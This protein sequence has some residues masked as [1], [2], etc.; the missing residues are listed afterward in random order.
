[1]KLLILKIS[2][3][4]FALFL[5]VTAFSQTAGTLTFIY[6]PTSHTCYTG[7]KNVLA[8]WVQTSTG[9]FVKTRIRNA[10]SGTNDHLPTWAVN[11]GGSAGNCMAAACNVTGAA[12]T[13]ATLSS[14]TTKNITWDGTDVTGTVVADGTYKI[15]IQSTWNHGG[16]GTAT[17]SFTFTKGPS[18][19]VQAP[20]ND[21]NF[22]NMTL[23]WN[24]ASAAGVEEN[25]LASATIYPN[26]STD[27]L[28]NVEYV[29]AT[30]IKVVNLVGMTIMEE[31][32]DTQSGTK[33]IDLSSY[34]NGIYLVSVSNGAKTAE[35]KIVLDK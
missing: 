6:T 33:S 24:P 21:A 26:P 27:G 22:T 30:A 11:S 13:G 17:R 7:S 31:N 29:N 3:T 28:F 14:F 23:H 32:L 18:S 1:M 34:T 2:S 9:T 10:G 25:E 16:T 20:A 35:Y 19:D 4:A 15:T 12:T 8:V 5:S